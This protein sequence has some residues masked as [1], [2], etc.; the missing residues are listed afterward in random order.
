M[1]KITTYILVIVV[2][3]IGAY[4][5]LACYSLSKSDIEELITYCLYPENNH[6]PPGLPQFYMLNF[7]GSKKDLE[8]LKNHNGLGFILNSAS[9]QRDKVIKYVS[10]FIEKG[11]DINSVGIDGSTALQVA[12]LFN[13]PDEVSFLLKKGADRSIRVGYSRI[14]GKNEKTNFY[15]MTP[16]ELAT[17]LSKKD[18]Q[19]RSRIIKMLN[20]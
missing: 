5:S 16:L 20:K 9:A 11:F 4:F 3:L 7:R 19:D 17:Y 12:I 6:Y 1:K 13:H 2:V 18:G 10:F 15:G 8:L 14:H